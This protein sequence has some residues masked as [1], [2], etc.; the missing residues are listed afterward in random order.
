MLLEPSRAP[1]GIAEKAAEFALERSR[2]TE[3]LAALHVVQE[4]MRSNAHAATQILR[5]H[6][7]LLPRQSE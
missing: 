1:R 3:V 2:D 7:S 4:H 5:E 6:E